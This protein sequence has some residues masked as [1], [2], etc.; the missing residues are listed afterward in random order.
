MKTLQRIRLIN[1]HRFTNETIELSDATLL[2]GE[3]GAGKSTILDAI[4]LVITASKN[5]FNKAAQDKGKRTLNTYIRCKTGREDRPYE[6]TGEL[7]AHVALEFYD[8][9]RK[10]PFIIGVVM[11]SASEEKEPNTVWYLIERRSFEDEMFFKGSQVRSISSFHSFNGKVIRQWCT[12]QRQAQQMLLQR[13]GRLESKFFTLIP[14][15]LAFK[16]ISDIKDFVY[17]YVLDEKAVNIDALR[18]NVRSYQDLTRTL[19]DVRKRIAELEAISDKYEQ[20]NH[21]IRIDQY[22]E[23]YLARVEQDIL[24]ERIQNLEAEMQREAIREKDLLRKLDEQ[25]QAIRTK[26]ETITALQVELNSNTDYQAYLEL[27][28]KKQELEERLKENLPAVKT[29]RDHAGKALKLIQKLAGQETVTG[30]LAPCVGAYQELLANF[31]KEESF[32]NFRDTQ[33]QVI[34][35]KKEMYDTV[36]RKAGTTSVRIH[37]HEEKGKN[38][39]HEIRELENHKMVY[40]PE[41]LRL[42][43]SIEDQFRKSGRKDDV[44]ILCEQLEITDATWQNAVEGYLNTQRFYLL[45]SPENFDLGTNV[46]DRLRKEHKAY[47]VGLINTD[48]L[49]GYDKAPEGSLAEK[50]TSKNL[51]ARR[52]VNMV[53]GKVHCVSRPEEL[54]LYPVSI[55]KGCMRY[56]NH[57]VSAIRP[58]IFRTPYIGAKAYEIQLK[59]KKEELSDLMEELEALKAKKLEEERTA[60][61]LDTTLDMEVKYNLH[62]I[63]DRRRDQASLEKILTDRKALDANKTLLEKEIRLQELQKEKQDLEKERSGIDRKIGSAREKQENDEGMVNS[64]KEEAAKS[65]ERIQNLIQKLGDSYQETETNYQKEKMKRDS[66]ESF[67]NGFENA[68]KANE[69]RRQTYEKDLEEQMRLYKIAHDFGA[70]AEYNGYP[71]FHNEYV[72]LKESRLLEYEDQVAKARQAAEEEFREQF[73][74]KLQENIKQARQEFRELNRALKDIHFA[75]EQYEFQYAPKASLGKYYSMIMDDFNVM[76]GASIFSG[77]FEANHREVIEELFE[78]LALD[79]E[80]SSE[81]LEEYTDYRTYMDYDIRITA[82]DGSYMLYSK[83]SREKSGGETQTPFYITVAAS[84]M[85]MYRNSIGGDSIGLMMMDEAFNNMDDEHIRGVL[86]FMRSTDLQL[87]ISAP[88]EKIQ[89]I[90][91]SMDKVLLV[92]ADGGQS[93]VDDFTHEV[94]V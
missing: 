73:L 55:T 17:S 87:I 42:K 75:H 22:Q 9:Q 43:G 88:P 52:Y 37:D 10:N 74:S 48:R 41:V 65:G 18:E 33:E 23:Y 66:L 77:T 82:D 64:L 61:C 86:S 34:R 1:W 91:P 72:R 5:N 24:M 19:E 32:V 49:D 58:D 7:S 12:T 54:K 26:E 28:R 62:Y 69:T 47:G 29:L 39:R 46:Y 79:D 53:L 11:D 78:K 21:C 30:P 63:E 71:A 92:L 60:G 90:G 31:D 94:S 56:Q 57:V 51:Y 16:P 38:L 70:P 50:V 25:V 14:K 6:R 20:V 68:R 15:A 45:V 4:Q 3:N 35:Y 83:V 8:E 13:F 40:P 59:N 2:S 89:Y 93:Y 36:T 81:T 85:Q 84:F 80:N 44:R 67:R 76:Q 27:D